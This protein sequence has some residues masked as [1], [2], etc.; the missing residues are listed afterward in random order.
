[1]ISGYFAFKHYISGKEVAEPEHFPV[2]YA[3]KKLLNLVA[4]SPE[5]HDLRHKCRYIPVLVTV[6]ITVWVIYDYTAFG[7]NSGQYYEV[8]AFREVSGTH[9]TDDRMTFAQEVFDG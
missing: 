9:D 8:A 2:I 5:I 6:L 4:V 7:I 3:V 1:M